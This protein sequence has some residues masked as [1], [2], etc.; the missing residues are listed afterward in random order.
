M[1]KAI[2]PG[3]LLV[4]T[5]ALGDPNFRRGVVLVVQHDA[6]EG[7]LG[8]V[9][10]RPSDVP[11]G[12]VL[13]SWA[14][15]VDHPTVV[16]RG[17]PVALDSALCLAV[18]RGAHD[19]G[20]E[21]LGWRS[22]EGPPLAG[23]L[24]LVDLDTPPEVVA[25]ELGALRIFAGYAG[26]GVGQLEHEI[27]EGAWYLL[28]PVPGDPFVFEPDR[29]WRDVLRRQGGALAVVATCPEDPTLN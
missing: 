27:E 12:K 15:L 26:W 16:F 5:P 6:E 7:T 14:D 18:L 22:L 17:G 3:R 29:M 20:G 1:D 9:L 11:V 10:N 4:A 23:R 2:H 19:P 24:G 8:V 28:D 21:P 13:P 25:A